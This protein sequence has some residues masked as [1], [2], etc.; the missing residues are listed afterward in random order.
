VPAAHSLIMRD[1]A[2]MQQVVHFLEHGKFIHTAQA[3]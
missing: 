3:Q 1:G 2:V